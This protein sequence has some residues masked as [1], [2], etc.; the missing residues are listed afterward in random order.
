VRSQM[1][2][3]RRAGLG[4]QDVSAIFEYTAGPR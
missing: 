3:A 2:A 4:G 1:Q